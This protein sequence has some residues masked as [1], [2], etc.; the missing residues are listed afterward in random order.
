MAFSD[1]GVAVRGRAPGGPD[2]ERRLRALAD[3][4]GGTL[5]IADDRAARGWLPE[6]SRP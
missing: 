3:A 4:C 1:G 2:A 5:V 6:V